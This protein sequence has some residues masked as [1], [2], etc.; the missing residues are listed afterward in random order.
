MKLTR[1]EQE[2]II[3]T[4]DA[5]DYWVI[6]TASPK[7]IRKFIKLGYQTDDTLLSPDGY[8]SFK[9]PLN[10]ISFRRP[11]RTLSEKETAARMKNLRQAGSDA[12]RQLGA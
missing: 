5:D 6:S 7:H 11:R 2:T 8:R 4:S 12:L 10:L 3:G 1:A 9:V